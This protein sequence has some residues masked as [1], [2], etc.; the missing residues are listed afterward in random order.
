[1]RRIAIAILALT[2]LSVSAQKKELSQ[3]RSYIKSGKDY[4]KAEKLMTDLLAKDTVNRHNKKIYATWY[5]S[6]LGQYQQINE[7]IYL[8]QKYDT[9][10]VYSLLNR[11]FLVAE[12]LDSIDAQPDK[13]G[14]V[15]PEYRKTNAE[16]LDKLR[17]NLYFGGTYNLRRGK[18]KESFNYLET[19][20]DAARQPLFAAY[21]YAK[22]DTVMPTAAYWATLAGYR[23]KDA[24]LTL[25]YSQ[26]AMTDTSKAVFVRQYICEAYLW[27]KNDEA[28]VK[29]LEDGF[30]HHPEYPYFFPRLGDYYNQHRQVE[31]TL[32]LSNEA[33]SRYPDRPLFL[34]AKSVALLELNR[35]EECIEVSNKLIAKNAD[36]PEPYLNI[37]TCYLNDALK[38]EQQKDARAHRDQIIDLYTKARPFMEEYRKLAPKDQNR[39]A[40]ALYRIYFNLNIGKQFEEIDQLMRKMK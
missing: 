22:N 38:L 20:I 3:A 16:Q 37:A 23:M 8:R 5:E 26:Q 11:L 33:L 4:D 36:M 27:Q 12:S 40:P 34:L 35:N 9:A 19:Y 31:K 28:Y 2:A 13:K 30:E 25:R 17:R 39:W 15:K 24:E 7:K 21:D 6:V 14:K 10:T 32:D 1:M 29:A 18:N